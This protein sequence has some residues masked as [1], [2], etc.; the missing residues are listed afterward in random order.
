MFP[1]ICI[2]D[3]M[4]Y[5]NWKC[6]LA[7]CFIS[8]YKWLFFQTSILCTWID[9][10]NFLNLIGLQWIHLI[11]KIIFPFINN[12]SKNVLIHRL[13]FKTPVLKWWSSNFILSTNGLSNKVRLNLFTCSKQK[14]QPNDNWNSYFYHK[15]KLLQLCP[16]I[17]FEFS[18]LF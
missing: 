12:P 6:T 18:V 15:M 13:S 17:L 7:Y 14:N 4:Y 9:T 3:V 1:N 16:K 2:S 5:K 11:I 10:V 8:K